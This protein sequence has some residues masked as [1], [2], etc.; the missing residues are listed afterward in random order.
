MFAGIELTPS[1]T[2]SEIQ[3]LEGLLNKKRAGSYD[4]R[5]RFADRLY[6]VA[7]YGKWRT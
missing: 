7:D 3:H 1:G 2:D 4:T 5:N 6:F